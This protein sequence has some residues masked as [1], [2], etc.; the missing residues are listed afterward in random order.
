MIV[1]AVR[2][3]SLAVA[4]LFTL[5]ACSAQVG[6]TGSGAAAQTVTVS[7][8][9]DAA[10]LTTGQAAQFAATVTGSEDVAVTWQVDESAGGSVDG[11]GLYTA[12]LSAGTYHVRA[13]SHADG[14][15]SAIATVTVVAPP[16][17][18]SVAISPKTVSLRTSAK[19]TFTATATNLSS[20][21][22]NWS[23]QETGCG[24]ITSA[25]V[26]T[27]PSAAK[28]CHVVAAS[29]ADGTKTDVATVTVTAAP[30]AL[31]ISP[32]APTLDACGAQTFTANQGVT[33][34]VLE[35]SAGGTISSAGAYVAPAGGGTY[36]VVATPTAGGT[37]AQVAVV[38]VE[39]IV[40]VNVTPASGSVA[41][42]GTVRFAATVTTTCGTYA[43]T[44]VAQ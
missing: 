24:S 40:S 32:S 36:H 29:A 34:S 22:I 15:V 23:I 41:P 3:L 30:A 2:P 6:T 11:T 27:A 33:W 21:A 7:V 18:G 10:T 37:A 38:V 20:T 25:G 14:K 42:G 16:P 12:P 19:L 35:G 43:A 8:D 26:Y 1:R 28:T 9:P 39:R 44:T 17:S 5:A 31:S 13:V 4:V